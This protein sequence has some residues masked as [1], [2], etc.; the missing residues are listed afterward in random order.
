GKTYIIRRECMLIAKVEGLWVRTHA[1]IL[2]KIGNDEKGKKI[3][4]LF[5]ALAMEEWGIHPVPE[6]ERL[7]MTHYPK[8]FLEF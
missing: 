7:D 8:E 5:G 1:R 6:E 4:V 2:D 3:E